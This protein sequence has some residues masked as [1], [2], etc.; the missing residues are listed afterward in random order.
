MPLPALKGLSSS[1]FLPGDFQRRSE[2]RPLDG[3]LLN[4]PRLLTKVAA[5]FLDS[6]LPC[7]TA[8]SIDAVFLAS[9]AAFLASTT[10][11]AVS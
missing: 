11:S 1:P 6:P 10:Y 7:F 9:A 3:L 4:V 2:R 5:L 8:E